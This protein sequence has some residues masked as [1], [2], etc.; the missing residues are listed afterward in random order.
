MIPTVAV[1]G[2]EISI[3]RCGF[4]CGR[5]FGGS[6]LKAS[7]GLIE[8]ALIAGIRHFDTAPSYG[9][10][11]SEAV[12]GAVLAGVP[13]VTIATKIGIPRPKPASYP[14]QV[15]YRRMVRPV[16]SRFPA[17]KARLR[18]MIEGRGGVAE[19]DPGLPR[20]RLGRD[21]V[22]RGLDESLK[23]LRRTR[24]DLYLVHE[25]DQFDLTDDLRALLTV[26]QRSGQVGSFGLAWGCIADTSLAFGTVIQGRHGA[27]LPARAP[28]GGTRVFH[29]VLRHGWHGPN[30]RGGLIRGPGARIREVLDA[31]PD[32][33]VIFSASTP[34]Q[35]RE[36]AEQLLW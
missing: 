2:S 19:P 21:E 35:I 24:A 5:I 18:R 31:H 11:Q 23:Q 17:T 7:A 12:L 22:L 30:E 8:A 36:V 10:G 15:L 26:L 20:R 27:H 34:G 6:E 1:A 29:G 4:G 13:D 9:N 3:S 33:A 25:P 16:L 32:S 28:V 14:A